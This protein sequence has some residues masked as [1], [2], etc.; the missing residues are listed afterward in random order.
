VSR[1]P[2][3]TRTVSPTRRGWLLIALGALVLAG[4]TLE[5]AVAKK[6]KA[7]LSARVDGKRFKGMKRATIFLYATTSFSV[8][9][10]TR[11][12]R[13]VSRAITVNC[14]PIDLKAVTVPTPVL[15][16]FGVYQE[17]VVRG[18][19]GQKTWTTQAMELTVEFFDGTR[20]A[21]TFRGTVPASLSNP[22]EPPVTI[23]EG[24]FSAFVR[25]V[26]V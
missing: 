8:N 11:V 5:S 14:G 12:K 19:G 20:A 6:Q 2:N 22:D 23:E 10:Q 17:N 7:R 4:P 3:E 1:P 16:C 24:S 9:S 26:G 15:Q 18:A 21:G 25:D 13:G